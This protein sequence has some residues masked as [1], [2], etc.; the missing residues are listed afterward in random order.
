MVQPKGGGSG[1]QQGESKMLVGSN[2][3][4]PPLGGLI[5]GATVLQAQG[6]KRAGPQMSLAMTSAGMVVQSR[7]PKD[8]LGA[9]AP[10]TGYNRWSPEEVAWLEEGVVRYGVGKWKEILRAYEFKEGRTGVDLKDKFRNLQVAQGKMEKRLSYN[11]KYQVRKDAGPDEQL[12]ERKKK[13]FQ[14]L[15][16]NDPNGPD[17]ESVNEDIKTRGSGRT[18]FSNYRPKEAALKAATRGYTDIRLLE[19]GSNKIHCFQ[20]SRERIHLDFAKDPR[21]KGARLERFQRKDKVDTYKSKVNKIKTIYLSEKS[22][23]T[24]KK[25]D[26]DLI[27]PPR[28]KVP[29]PKRQKVEP[30]SSVAP[31]MPQPTPQTMHSMIGEPLVM[32]KAP[33]PVPESS[34]PSLSIFSAARS[35]VDAVSRRMSGPK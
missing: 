8:G 20:G 9:K 24:V 5:G 21:L 30:G 11:G 25:D 1:V 23:K 19:R 2:I 4:Q 15:T 14:L 32:P 26:D 35:A 12:A 18:T 7:K 29:A 28:I 16:P 22:S 10:H 33:E 31:K 27:A 34:H 3:L 13:K 17:P 6:H